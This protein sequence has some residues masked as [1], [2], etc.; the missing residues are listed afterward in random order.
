MNML[1]ASLTA[2]PLRAATEPPLVCRLVDVHGARWVNPATLDAFLAAGGD[3][4]L[5]FS[6]DPVRFPE[7]LDVAVV[8]PELR[9][10]FP[11]R[12]Q[13]GVVCRD[14]ELEVASR[15]GSQNWPALVFLRD[16]RFVSQIV[17][18]LDWTVY[19]ERVAQALATPATRPPISLTPVQTGH[20]CH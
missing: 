19:L 9:K 10:A 2:G 6:G 3:Q 15:F 13:L 8:L 12:F 7:V 11:G 1:E 5:F 4:V 18:M 16:G 14:G 17:G 20:A